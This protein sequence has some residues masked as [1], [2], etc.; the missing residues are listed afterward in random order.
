LAAA[1]ILV[2]CL[3][4]PFHLW[5]QEKVQDKANRLRELINTDHDFARYPNLRHH[6]LMLVSISGMALTAPDPGIAQLLRDT[7]LS[8]REEL[9]YFRLSHEE[10]RYFLIASSKDRLTMLRAVGLIARVVR[11]SNIVLV[12]DGRDLEKELNTLHFSDGLSLPAKNAVL[13]VFVPDKSKREPFQSYFLTVY[14]QSFTYSYP[15]KVYKGSLVISGDN[16][17][18]LV[19]RQLLRDQPPIQTPYCVRTEIRYDSSVV[20]LYNIQGVGL[21]GVESLFGSVAA[22]YSKGGTLFVQTSRFWG[23]FPFEGFEDPA[24]SYR[25][26]IHPESSA[27]QL[28]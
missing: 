4:T 13:Y 7:H 1:A 20:G 15:R 3:N 9:P 27:A 14:N 11:W 6:V 5:C 16:G 2:S 8:G 23:R 12:M 19:P 10:L 28:P 22:M 21:P 17:T 18:R 24:K 25:F 26:A